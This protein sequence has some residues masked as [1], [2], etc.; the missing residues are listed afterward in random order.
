ML[1]GIIG[2]TS[3]QPFISILFQSI[4]PNFFTSN[5]G[6]STGPILYKGRVSHQGAPGSSLNLRIVPNTAFTGSSGMSSQ[7]FGI[8]YLNLYFH[9]DDTES[10]STP[11]CQTSSVIYPM[12]NQCPCN[13]NQGPDST[14]NVCESCALGCDFCLGPAIDQCLTCVILRL[15]KAGMELNVF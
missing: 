1:L 11:M 8:R 13:L 4:P 3:F 9:T 7:Y 15:H 10:T 12:T 5:D 6:H 14:T 2:E